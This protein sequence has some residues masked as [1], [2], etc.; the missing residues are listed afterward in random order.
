MGPRRLEAEPGRNL[1]ASRASVHVSM[2]A[3]QRAVTARDALACGWPAVWPQPCLAAFEFEAFEC[4]R[5]PGRRHK[6]VH[7]DFPRAG[8]ISNLVLSLRPEKPPLGRQRE[9]QPKHG[10]YR[11]VDFI[12]AP[13]T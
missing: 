5:I 1:W 2:R 11:K 6:T 10:T 13:W 9:E 4:L 3:Q 12:L 8:C 7:G